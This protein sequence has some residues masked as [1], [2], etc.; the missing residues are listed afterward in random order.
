M[1]GWELY[2]RV[3]YGRWEVHNA[4]SCSACPMVLCH[5]QLADVAT[6]THPCAGVWR[7][8]IAVHKSVALARGPIRPEVG[9]VRLYV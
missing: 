5:A 2:V 9:Q 6:R 1:E 4:Q 8:E 7:G 3:F